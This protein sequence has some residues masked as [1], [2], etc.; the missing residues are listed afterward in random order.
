M[1]D[2]GGREAVGLR[3]RSP[4][5]GLDRRGLGPIQVFGQS[6]SAAAP[7]AAMATIPAI[8]AATAG[9]A[10]VWS[11][12]GATALAL[13]VG[14]CIAQFTRRMAAAGS[15][16]S[17]TAKGLGPR[18]AFAGGFALLSGYALLLMLSFTGAAMSLI[19]LLG[20]LGIALPGRVGAPAAVAVLAGL[21]LWLT[22]R[23]TR[24]SAQ[25]VL[26]TESVS[27]AL[28]L[29]VFGVLLARADAAA[30]PAVLAPTS[31]QFGGIAA[32]IVPALGGFIGFEA[33]ASLGVEAR[34]PFRSVPRAVLWTAAI[35]GLL[36]LVATYTH[37]V[38]ATGLE[39]G[40]TG[41]ADP[42]VALAA[43]QGLPHLAIVLDI[44]IAMSFFACALAVANAL[45]R[46]LFSM[47]R[48]GVAPTVFGRAHPRHRTP[49]V[50]L[51]AGIGA[52]AAAPIAA[53][54]A[55]TEPWELLVV[56]TSTS[57]TG[58]LL[59]YLLVSLAAPVF[60]RRIGE[61]TPTAAAAAAL[62]VPSLAA[63][64]AVFTL[65][66]RDGL[67]PVIM[68][69]LAITGLAWYVW[70]RRRPAAL[71]RIGV[72]DETTAADVWRPR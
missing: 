8:A 16:Y 11:F 57:A 1:S 69:F 46:V 21:A 48:E 13:L 41:Q 40:F 63:V 44:G 25:V 7:S 71:A 68:A 20:R 36:Y 53:L 55:G 30:D 34:R 47:G 45:A 10:V 65:S 39:G 61:L 50:A 54:A 33:A 56:L 43:A 24:L 6:V 15:L 4:V 27:V 62:A 35:C 29:L 66:N 32:G 72:Y 22:V 3:E 23:G 52:A 67:F 64:L 9:G 59:A 14:V 37:V 60:L 51:T 49:H 2:T 12:V 19:D 31:G 26:V 18:A 58:Y 17:L 28:M 70:L 38:G 42:V 5:S